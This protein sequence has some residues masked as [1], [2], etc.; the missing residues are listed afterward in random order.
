MAVKRIWHGWTKP[1]NAESYQELLHKEVFPGIETRDIRGY[2]CV[3]LFRRN[4]G[5]E[6]EFI[7]IMTFDSL[8]DVKKFRG[9]DYEQCYVPEK[10]QQLLERWD[11][12]ASHYESVEKRVHRL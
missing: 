12:I 9:K 2:Q 6:V 11:K 4:M 8:E 7:T 5:S 10:A 3:E 1:E